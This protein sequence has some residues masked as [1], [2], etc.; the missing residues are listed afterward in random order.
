MIA[1]SKI[2]ILIIPLIILGLSYLCLLKP[3]YT[4]LQTTGGLTLKNLKSSLETKEDYLENLKSL[5]ISYNNLSTEE[6]DKLEQILPVKKD[7]P[8]LFVHFQN[9]VNLQ[10]LKL[11]AISF[12]EENLEGKVKTL[13]INLDLRGGNY[14]ILKSF[15][16]NLEK[17]VKIVDVVSINFAKE[18]YNLKLKTYYLTD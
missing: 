8:N 18:G 3:K 12:T 16:A 5:K 6:K 2:L 15:L 10:G 9:L 4:K 1:N 14:Q 17:D 11:A 7:I 13:D